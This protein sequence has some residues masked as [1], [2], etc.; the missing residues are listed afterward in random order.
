ML[1]YYCC[2]ENNVLF[3]IKIFLNIS[4]GMKREKIVIYVNGVC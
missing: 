1:G 3:F 2:N 4:K